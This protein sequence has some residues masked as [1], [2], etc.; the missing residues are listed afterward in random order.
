MRYPRGKGDFCLKELA[1]TPT[2]A[3]MM[4]K[5]AFAKWILAFVILVVAVLWSS[6]TPEDMILDDSTAQLEFSTDTLRFDTIFTQ[7]G[8]ATRTL[9]VYNR[10]D[11]RVR[12][13]RI[14][15]TQGSVSRFR[16]N[17]NG[18]MGKE[19]TDVEILP[20]DSIYVFVEVTIDPD[21]PPSVSPFIFT[22]DLLFE[23]NEHS[24]R[25]VLEAWGQNANYIPSRFHKDSIVVFECNGGE[26]VWDDPKPYVVYGI[27]AFE[28]CTLRIPAGVR[29]YVHGGLTRTEDEQ[30][31]PLIYNS[32]R[33]FIGPNGRLVVEGTLDEPVIFEGDRL[34]PEFADEPGQWTGII[35]A[36]GSTGNSI[37]HA[38]I[39]NSLVGVWVDSAAQLS[40][41]NTRIYNTTGSAVVGRHATIT[42][43]NCLFYNCGADAVRLGHGG[44]YRFDYCTL[45]SYGVDAGALSL[46]NGICYD[47]LCQNFDINKLFARFRNCIIAGSRR[48]EI[49]L[50]DFTSGQDPALFDY[51]LQYCVVRVDELLDEPNGYPDFFSYC[52]PCINVAFDTP[53][54]ANVAEDDYHLDSLSVAIGLAQPLMGF[55][56]DLEGWMRDDAPDAGCLEW[57][58]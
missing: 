10:Y 44:T 5:G 29:I 7:L 41:R 11:K 51:R 54:F 45:A 31:N 17:I 3:A 57:H 6:C 26:V 58:P 24:Q 18:W 4:E 52:D 23:W 19:I 25:V 13:D 37:E 39:R 1:C 42:A 35:F 38:V 27:V 49:S 8:S 12:I 47:P 30:G 43:G 28:D 40:L 14:A 48:D 33:L 16:M 9:K 56:L 34:E 21:Q 15:F 46:S 20:H 36:P 53:L 2:F 55:E 32:G 22:E 50:S